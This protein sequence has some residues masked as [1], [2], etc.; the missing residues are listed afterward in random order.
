MYSTPLSAPQTTVLLDALSNS[1]SVETIEKVK[2]FGSTDLCEEE[3]C[4]AL[5]DF[6]AAA[7]NMTAFDIRGNLGRLISI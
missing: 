4:V 3:A 2:L 5:A 1:P 7:T 6:L